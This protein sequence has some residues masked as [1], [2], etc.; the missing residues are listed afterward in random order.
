MEAMM[1]K[2]KVAV[3]K[4]GKEALWRDYWIYSKTKGTTAGAPPD[5]GRTE[6]V[7]ASTLEEAIDAVQSRNPDCTIMLA[8]GDHD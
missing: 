1:R 6:L 8:G 5:L 3:V 4:R 7:E 2:F